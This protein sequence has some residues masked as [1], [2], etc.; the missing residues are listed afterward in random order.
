MPH[1][2]LLLKFFPLLCQLLP[3]LLISNCFEE[4]KIARRPLNRLAVFSADNLEPRKSPKSKA[5]ENRFL[6]IRRRFSLIFSSGFMIFQQ[7]F[8][9]N[10]PSFAS[11]A[12]SKEKRFIARSLSIE[13]TFYQRKLQ[14]ESVERPKSSQ[15]VLICHL[16]C[17][18]PMKSRPISTSNFAVSAVSSRQKLKITHCVRSEVVDWNKC[19]DLRSSWKMFLVK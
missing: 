7:F 2:N 12:A 4:V 14:Q 10:L 5:L 1:K 16:Y 19:D 11:H 8:I 13:K 9:I 18:L 6:S 15:D 17:L 3:L